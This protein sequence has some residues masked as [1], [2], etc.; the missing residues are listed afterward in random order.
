[1]DYKEHELV[2]QKLREI[3]KSLRVSVEIPHD[4]VDRLIVE[5]LISIRNSEANRN[6]DMLHFDKT[7]KHFLTEDEFIKY[8]V[9]KEPI[10]E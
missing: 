2:I 4:E 7:I 3:E 8:V 5:K 1:M 9:N 6:R 10:K